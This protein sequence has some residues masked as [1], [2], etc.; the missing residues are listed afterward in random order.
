MFQQVWKT[1]VVSACMNTNCVP[2]TMA[3][4]IMEATNNSPNNCFLASYYVSS[5]AL[6]METEVKP[7]IV[8]VICF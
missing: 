5:A 4:H 7:E 6:R 3:L 1:A 2:R 8:L